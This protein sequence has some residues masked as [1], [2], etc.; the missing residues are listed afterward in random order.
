MKLPLISIP[1]SLIL[2]SSCQPDTSTRVSSQPE[3][4]ESAV[5]ADPTRPETLVGLPLAEAQAAADRMK[6]PHRVVSIDGK[7]LPRTFD[8]HQNR[9][10]F[11]VL[12]GVVVKVKRG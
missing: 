2:L 6:I 12:K 10:N 9:L 11:T 5:V 3:R 8:Y 4:H 1:C 7:S